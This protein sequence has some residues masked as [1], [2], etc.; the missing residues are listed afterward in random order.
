MDNAEIHPISTFSSL[1]FQPQKSVAEPE[2]DRSASMRS[3]YGSIFLM[4]THGS[5]QARPQGLSSSF[6]N[7]VGVL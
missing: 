1:R 2:T 7:E 5:F 6:G 4:E 3:C